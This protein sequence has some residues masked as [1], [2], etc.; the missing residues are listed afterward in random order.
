MGNF[1]CVMYGVTI[2]IFIILDLNGGNGRFPD[3][4]VSD[5]AIFVLERDVKLQLTN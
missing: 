5:I 4:L 2:D 1:L 3:N